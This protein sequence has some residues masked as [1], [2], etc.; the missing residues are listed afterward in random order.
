MGV[1]YAGPGLYV[2][3]IGVGIAQRFDVQRLGVGLYGGFDGVEVVGIDEGS[4]YAVGQR[5]GVRKQIVGAAVY[6]LA[7]HYVLAAHGQRQYRVVDGCRARGGGQRRDAAFQRSDALLEYVLRRVGQAAIDVARV[8]QTKAVGGM[9]AVV[10]YKAGGGV[11]RH[12][13]GVGGGVGLL[14]ADVQLTGLKAPGLAIL[15]IA[16]FHFL[17]LIFV[18]ACAACV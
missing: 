7:G 4:G 15:N 16:H 14:L 2:G 8:A 10:E 11:Y 18:S 13:A 5:Q 3:H 6:G 9:L 1:R 17:R 12:R